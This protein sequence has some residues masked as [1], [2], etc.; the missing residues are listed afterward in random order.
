MSIQTLEETMAKA[1]PKKPPVRDTLLGF[2]VTRDM[3]KALESAAINESRSVSGL[4][5]WI[6]ADWLKLHKYL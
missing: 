6:L 4:V 5:I 2:R 3:K 1:P